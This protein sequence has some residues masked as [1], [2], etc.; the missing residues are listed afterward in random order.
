MGGVA[1]F[2]PKTTW[3]LADMLRTPGRIEA[4][5]IVVATFLIAYWN[6]SKWCSHGANGCRTL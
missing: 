6:G 3:L 4:L 1:R 2:N 5:G